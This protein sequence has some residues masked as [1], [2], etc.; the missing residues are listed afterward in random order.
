LDR[1]VALGRVERVESAGSI[2]YRSRELVLGLED[3]TGWE[4]A[5]LDHFSAL[6]QTITRKLSIEQAAKAADEIGG[7]TYHFVVWRGHPMEDEV[8]GELRRFRE[9]QSALRERVDEYNRGHGMPAERLQVTA[10][11]GQSVMEGE[12]VPS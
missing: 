12:D 3:P 9:R 4:A 7:S 6:V 11:Y 8:L 10:Y 1:L 5:V 2:D